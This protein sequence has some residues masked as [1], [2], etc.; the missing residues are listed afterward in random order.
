MPETLNLLYLS[1]YGTL[2]STHEYFGDKTRLVGVLYNDLQRK[3]KLESF[4]DEN[5]NVYNGTYKNKDKVIPI[6]V[7]S[8][9]SLNN[10]ISSNTLEENYFQP[11]PYVFC[12]DNCEQSGDLFTLKI[13]IG[14]NDFKLSFDKSRSVI[15]FFNSLSVSE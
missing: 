8:L 13:N 3:I 10:I 5:K 14:K 11:A 15:K 1:E 9:G 12:W 7:T 2:C 4:F 6:S